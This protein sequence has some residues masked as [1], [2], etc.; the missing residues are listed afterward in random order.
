M[1][2]PV[3]TEQ[4]IDCIECFANCTE[5]APFSLHP[6]PPLTPPPPPPL[7]FARMAGQAG[8]QDHQPTTGR[9]KKKALGTAFSS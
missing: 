2:R 5:I 9:R 6:T 1:E 3:I 4:L 7:S 8:S